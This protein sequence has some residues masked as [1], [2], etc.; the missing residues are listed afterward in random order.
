MRVWQEN[1]GR[2]VGLSTAAAGDSARLA[3]MLE[4]EVL[5]RVESRYGTVADLDGDG[6][7]AICLTAR[8]EQ[9]PA[10]G[11]AVEGLTQIND[12]LTDLPRPFSNQADVMFLSQAL[13][14]GPHARTILTHEAAHLA[15]FSRRHESSADRL[16]LEDDWLN[17]GL[18]HWAE[19]EC[20]NDWSNLRGRLE[21]FS[22]QPSLSPLVV[23]DAH[24]QGLW[25]QPGSRA[26]AWL[27]LRWLADEFGTE[28]I[29]AAARDPEVGCEKISRLAGVS[30]PELFRRWSVSTW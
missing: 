13:R 25:R 22:R 15:V 10:E 14:P 28:L 3:E 20:A 7:L 23:I 8:L 6:K 2:Q 1:A 9:L 19:T 29:P 21:A 4:R 27:F 16:A 12:F 18:A 24:Q 5:P 17:E 11:S 30:W 26:A